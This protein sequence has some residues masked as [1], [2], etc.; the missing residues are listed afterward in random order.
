MIQVTWY[1][2][3]R[4]G[5]MEIAPAISLHHPGDKTPQLVAL[6]IVYGD[7]KVFQD[8]KYQLCGAED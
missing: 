8:G 4:K 6:T 5:E 2:Y 7:T 3:D 1:C